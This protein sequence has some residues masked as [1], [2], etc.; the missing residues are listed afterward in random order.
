M[1]DFKR[2]MNN[3][4][5]S[6]VN[7]DSADKVEGQEQYIKIDDNTE[8]PE[9]PEGDINL[10]M[11]ELSN[12]YKNGNELDAEK[13]GHVNNRTGKFMFSRCGKC[14]GPTLGHKVKEADCEDEIDGDLAEAICEEIMKNEMFEVMLA[15]FD[16]RQA[17]IKCPECEMTF[18]TRLKMENHQKKNHEEKTSKDI[19]EKQESNK[20]SLLEG[21]MKA[22]EKTFE[23]IEGLANN[24]RNGRS[25]QITKAK[26][27]PI[28]VGQSF[29]RYQKVVKSWDKSNQ[30]NPAVKYQD[31]LESL[32]KNKEIKDYVITVILDKTVE[33]DDKTVKK[34]LSLLE[35]KYDKTTVEKSKEVLKEILEF[36]MKEDESCE[37][38][39]DKFQALVTKCQTE[40]INE[41][42]YYLLGN[43]MIN[44]AKDRGKLNEEEKRRLFDTIET[45][46]G[47]DSVPKDEEEVIENLK[48]EFKKL[49][50]ENNRGEMKNE[51]NV[52]YG[53]NRSRWDDWKQFKNNPGFSK[54]KRSSSQPGFWGTNSGNYRR[55]PSRT[56]SRHGSG[57]RSS[58]FRRTQSFGNGSGKPFSGKNGSNNRDQSQEPRL[59]ERV[60]SLEEG[61][62]KIMKKQ[63]DSEDKLMKKLEEIVALK[64]VNFVEYD[65][66]EIN[67]EIADVMF[68]QEVTRVES[69]VMDTGCPKSLV[70]RDWMMKYL[71][72]NNLEIKDMRTRNAY[73]RF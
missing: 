15:S 23:A 35:E 55:A 41:K 48:K 43:M 61:M 46:K 5:E 25:T 4:K 58:S 39:W 49:K 16:T 57:N 59:K 13:F 28:W 54:Y 63:N 36:D 68:L 14:T 60:I 22:Q 1:E 38:Y 26:P 20:D 51:T 7:L 56:P 62:A 37:K 71:K 52:H 11:E 29:E 50:I 34:V 24:S 17:A 40:K 19:R 70:G 64:D 53:E 8:D 47:S 12:K 10:K 72:K 69:M 73:Q 2:K 66:K 21:M 32:K 31:L 27:P 65:N 18:S 30:D 3:F 9:A 33:I 6:I 45:E 42:L 44:K 67:V